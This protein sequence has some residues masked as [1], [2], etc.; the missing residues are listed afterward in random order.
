MNYIRATLRYA[1]LR[2]GWKIIDKVP[3]LLIW[4][5]RD[6]ALSLEMAELSRKYAKNF[7][8]KLI[9]GAS[10]WVQQDAPELVNTC[11]KEYL[12]S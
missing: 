12:E 8:L 2:R 3:L 9:E 10:H 11:M 1:P 4:G 5:T 6:G 7:S